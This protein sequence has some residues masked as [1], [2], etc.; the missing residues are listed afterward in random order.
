MNEGTYMYVYIFIIHSIKFVKFWKFTDY[1]VINHRAFIALSY[2]SE[3][4]VF[5][6]PISKKGCTDED[7]LEIISP[8]VKYG[9]AGASREL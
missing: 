5:E 8:Q 2:P 3:F 4:I 6:L 9:S 1:L 7:Y